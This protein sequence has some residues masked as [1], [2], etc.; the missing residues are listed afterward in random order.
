MDMRSLASASGVSCTI[1]AITS[2]TCLVGLLCA[3]GWH[4]RSAIPFSKSVVETLG[5][6][7][8]DFAILSVDF[9]GLESM[10]E[11]RS[12]VELAAVYHSDV[13]TE[14]LWNN[15]CH[16]LI[17]WLR[18]WDAVMRHMVLRLFED[19]EVQS[20]LRT[21]TSFK[22][23][24]TSVRQ[25]AWPNPSSL[26]NPLAPT[27]TLGLGGSHLCMLITKGYE[28]KMQTRMYPN[29]PFRLKKLGRGG[30]DV[31]MQRESQ[32]WRWKWEVEMEAVWWS[33]CRDLR[34]GLADLVNV[35]WISVEMVAVSE[36]CNY[37]EWL[38]FL[39]SWF[40]RK[41]SVVCCWIES[42]L[43]FYPVGWDIASFR[44]ISQEG[45]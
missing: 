37:G 13:S 1:S 34:S 10:E 9:A 44:L 2:S 7:F 16:N 28:K 19:R 26:D 3:G 18:M 20:K 35:K 4:C 17:V 22:Y 38:A 33:R 45:E 5:S 31:K 29:L 27:Q 8:E 23:S 12:V 11:S 15:W 40:L 25:Q 42:L 43:I 14:I 39:L 30:G 24:T 6:G 21:F 36:R 32:A 41:R